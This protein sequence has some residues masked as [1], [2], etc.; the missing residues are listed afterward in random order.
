M[1]FCMNRMNENMKEALERD[2]VDCEQ[3]RLVGY[4]KRNKKHNQLPS[5]V[6]RCCCRHLESEGNHHNDVFNG[7][8]SGINCGTSKVL[9]ANLLRAQSILA[10][11]ERSLGVNCGTSTTS[12]SGQE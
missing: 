7:S 1:S 5:L 4:L 12:V 2:I 11:G 10:N 3:K 8:T 9:L 6:S